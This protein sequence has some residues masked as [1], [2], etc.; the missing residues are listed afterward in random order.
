M[1]WEPT[2]PTIQYWVDFKA[3]EFAREEIEGSRWNPT[4]WLGRYLYTDIHEIFFSEFPIVLHEW[5]SKLAT[6]QRN[7]QRGEPREWNPLLIERPKRVSNP[8]LR[9]VGFWIDSI[10]EGYITEFVVD[11]ITSYNEAE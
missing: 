5:L 9:V 8:V 10:L 4:E 6:Q 11:T 2:K 7:F 1:L 3:L